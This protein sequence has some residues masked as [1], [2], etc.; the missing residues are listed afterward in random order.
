[1]SSGDDELLHLRFGP[2]MDENDIIM[3]QWDIV[4]RLKQI[5]RIES[6]YFE[7][8]KTTELNVVG[9]TYYQGTWNITNNLQT[10]ANILS[11]KKMIDYDGGEQFKTT[12]NILS[13]WNDFHVIDVS[14]LDSIYD[15]S[16]VLDL[17]IQSE[18]DIDNV[19]GL[20]RLQAKDAVTG[21]TRTFCP[22]S[23]SNK[24]GSSV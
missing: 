17:A 20:G 21:N 7:F 2:N 18:W 12:I 3:Q 6:Q 1:M 9:E 14:G 16:G 15:Q 22:N 4:E 5:T 23:I 11:L 8:W 10:R 13:D 24:V 19:L